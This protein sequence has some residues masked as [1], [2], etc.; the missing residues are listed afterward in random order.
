MTLRRTDAADSDFR[1]LV[2]FLDAYLTVTDGDEHAFYDQYNSLDSIRHAV[3]AELDGEP[4]AC[5]AFKAFGDD[6]AE[7]KR[8]YCTPEHRG[9]GLATAVLTELERWA[10]AE[11]FTA[12]ILETGAF[13]KRRPSPSTSAAATN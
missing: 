12:T 1:R 2:T 10:S 4:V 3:V 9:R 6:S 13:A 7:I 8:M 11:G 5:G